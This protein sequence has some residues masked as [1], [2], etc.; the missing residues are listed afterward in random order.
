LL[1]TEKLY[2][3]DAYLREFTAQ[4]TSKTAL[5]DGKFAV[6]LDRT[7]FY[8]E[9]G[10]QPCDLGALNEAPVI[11]VRTIG[12]EIVHTTA[13]D[14]GDGPVTGR[15][16]WRR[17]FDHMQQHSGEHIL[18]GILLANY[19]A[20]NVGFH[21]SP[22]SC[23]ID[24]TLP[25]LTA[26]QA[27]AIEDAANAA[28]FANLP[29][30]GR[31]VEQT[32]LSAYRLR[33][34]PGKEFLQIRLVSVEDCDCCPCGGTHVSRTG[35]VGLLKIRNWEKR[36]QNI[37]LDF[38]CGNRALAD[39]RLKHE[40]ARALS[41]RFSAPVEG[42]RA[43]VE[44]TLEKLD[45][46]QSQLAACRKSYHEELAARLLAEA[47]NQGSGNLPV[48]SRIFVNYSAADLQDFAARITAG[49]GICLAA[50]S[51]NDGGRTSLLFSAPTAAP[52]PMN[53]LLKQALSPF[54][55]KGGGNALSAQGG[56]QGGDAEII[57]SSARK[58]L[59]L[60]KQE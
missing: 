38:V 40:L 32:E 5:A 17:R 52:L 49:G 46:S 39:Y 45:A 26:E 54:G 37:R 33:K 10:G 4:V 9:G 35:E 42:T 59:E 43:A 24:V 36:K 44:R 15:L 50:T 34:E 23:Q 27:T 19:Q 47:A 13:G 1:P 28:I 31:F 22:A 2:Y 41:S 18:S 16:D 30:T 25:S 56:L 6:V 21:L 20:E 55:G 7:A 60:E 29:V 3:Q 51:D 53:E 12:E 57:L 8:P 58:L 48:I 14:P 11:D